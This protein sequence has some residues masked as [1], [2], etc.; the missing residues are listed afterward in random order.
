[1]L[2]RSSLIQGTLKPGW[3]GTVSVGSGWNTKQ[4]RLGAALSWTYEDPVSVNGKF[5]IP[6]LLERY[7]TGSLST[8][9]LAS[10]EWSGTL[11]YSDQTLFGSPLHTS[12]GRTIAFQVQRKWGR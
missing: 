7:A 5:E 8:S 3:G 4:W 11:S 12:L 2:F 10:D 6:G 1:M 9:Y